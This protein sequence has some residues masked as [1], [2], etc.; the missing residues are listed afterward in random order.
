MN[1]CTFYYT[2]NN[3]NYIFAVKHCIRPAQTKVYKQLMNLFNR[4]KIDCYG[5]TFGTINY[6]NKF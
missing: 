6:K 4:D 3:V 2:K 5:F 1:R